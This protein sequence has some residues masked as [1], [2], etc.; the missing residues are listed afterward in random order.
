MDD[1]TIFMIVEIVGEAFAMLIWFSCGWFVVYALLGPW[2]KIRLIR[3]G[4][5]GSLARN[6]RIGP[7]YISHALF[8]LA[9]MNPYVLLTPVFKLDTVVDSPVWRMVLRACYVLLLPIAW[10]YLLLRLVPL[11]SKLRWLRCQAPLKRVVPVSMLI[12]IIGSTGGYA[13]AQ[14][15]DVIPAVARSFPLRPKSFAWRVN[16][17]VK[18][19]VD[20]SLSA[21]PTAMIID[22]RCVHIYVN[23]RHRK[24]VTVNRARQTVVADEG[25]I[26]AYV[27]ANDGSQTWQISE[28]PH[29]LVCRRAFDSK[30][31]VVPLPVAP[32][33]VFLGRQVNGLI[34]GANPSEGRL[35]AIDPEAGEVRWTAIAPAAK[36]ND[37]RRI[38]SIA[39]AGR[40]IAAGLWTSRVWAVDA[41]TGQT[42]WESVE[43]GY[44]N[45]MYVVASTE[46]VVAFSRSGRAYAFDPAT[47]EEKWIREV[48]DLA[49]GCGEGNVCIC[50]GRL[51]FQDNTTVSCLNPST[52]TTRWRHE[53]GSHY[54]GGVCRL[55]RDT[56][57]CASDRTLVLLDL[58]TGKETFATRFPVGSGIEYRWQNSIAKAPARIH[59]QS[60]WAPSGELY[61]FTT[62]GVLWCLKP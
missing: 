21:Q 53:F 17:D 37:D 10:D 30:S 60:V 8:S 6:T 4:S 61:V 7:V 3:W 12:S 62:D 44:G 16:T 28:H 39:D 25:P 32:D 38:G 59:A 29:G 40:I 48:G 20:N 9:L 57:A 2:L 33:A 52:G 47:G 1:A 46:A 42:L 34:V 56:V 13:A 36:G 58:E 19:L 49:G 41:G 35:Y 11:W 27:P 23:D 55:N 26:L 45:S 22:D 18:P 54:S 31:Q 14:M 43:E 51:I 5:H 15:K 50:S 24:W